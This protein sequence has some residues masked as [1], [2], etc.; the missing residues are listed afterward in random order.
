LVGH[1]WLRPLWRHRR[2]LLLRYLEPDLVQL[3]NDLLNL[4]AVEAELHLDIHHEAYANRA[5]V[6]AVTARCRAAGIPPARVAIARMATSLITFQREQLRQD[7]SDSPV[8][9]WDALMAAAA[10]ID[11][12]MATTAW[13]KALRD[14]YV[15]QH[16]Y[17]LMFLVLDS[18]AYR[19]HLL[20]DE[21]PRVQPWHEWLADLIATVMQEHGHSTPRAVALAQRRLASTRFA[22]RRA[23]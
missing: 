1:I 19:E 18:R 22:W 8:T 15:S 9:S 16:V 17:I 21:H 3:R 4:S 10:E 12:T 20:L 23:R 13:H 5:L 2:Q 7:L 11:Q 6:E 14:S